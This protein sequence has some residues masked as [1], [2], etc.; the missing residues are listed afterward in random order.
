MLPVGPGASPPVVASRV[1][2]PQPGLQVHPP[3]GEATS[4]CVP[5]VPTKL[6]V[7]L[8]QEP[9]RRPPRVLA[10][11]ARELSR[12]ARE[13]R[14]WAGPR[15]DVGTRHAPRSPG[16]LAA[17]LVDPPG[18]PRRGT[19][20]LAPQYFPKPRARDLPVYSSRASAGCLVASPASCAGVVDALSPAWLQHSASR[21]TA[22]WAF[23]IAPDSR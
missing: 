12:A 11:G 16:L 14:R 19:P 10:Q 9:V 20:F 17:S 8:H 6:E 13:P 2:R 7:R 15:W 21:R 1:A 3:A 4:P 23:R 18:S 5:A 22:S